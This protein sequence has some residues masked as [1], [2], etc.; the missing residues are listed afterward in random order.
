MKTQIE[1]F[2]QRELRTSVMDKGLCT[3]CGA[4]NAGCPYFAIYKDNTVAVHACDFKDGKCY[5]FC[6]RTPT[7]LERLRNEL[8]EAET[9]TD[10]LGPCLGIYMTRSTDEKIR[11]SAQHGGTI[12]TLVTLALEEGMID[13]AVLAGEDETHSAVGVL[14]RTAEDVRSAGK[15]K[16]PVSPTVA[17]FHEAAKGDLGKIGAVVTPCQ[18]LAFAKMRSGAAEIDPINKL[19]LVIGVFCGWALSWRG[20]KE[21]L[22]GRIGE[23]TIRGVD[24]PPS[25]YKCMEVYTE[26]GATV[27]PLDDVLPLV[28]DNCYCCSDMTCEFSDIAV[29][30]ARSPEGWEVDKG[31]NQLIVRTPLGQKLLDLA[32]ERG[33]LEFKDVP[34]GN[35]ERL[36][37]AST[38]KKRTAIKSLAE[39][40]GSLDDLLYLNGQDP[41]FRELIEELS[42]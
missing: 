6:P 9:L 33:L 31:W 39:K 26:S 20:L 41:I 7:D 2:G 29:G 23:E 32:R 13:G 25:K 10:E 34:E 3:G 15:S 36:K 11:A 24:I 30:S 22:K 12:S 16:F 17:A 35:L 21:L 38:N 28:R 19:K 8:Y 1:S 18:A 5:A 40:S 14:A 27:I 42:L 37:K 4:C